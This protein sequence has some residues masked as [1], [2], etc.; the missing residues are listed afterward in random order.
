MWNDLA[1]EL[2]KIAEIQAQKT[3]TDPEERFDYLWR[4]R[5]LVPVV[6]GGNWFVLLLFFVRAVTDK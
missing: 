4:H 3:N 5:W 6:I 1:G 2:W